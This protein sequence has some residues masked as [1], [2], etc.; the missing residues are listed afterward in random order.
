LAAGR[1]G[2]N[3][4][5]ELL[6]WNYQLSSCWSLGWGSREDAGSLHRVLQARVSRIKVKPSL[7]AQPAIF[8]NIKVGKT[9][10]STSAM[11]AGVG[12]IKINRRKIVVI[13]KARLL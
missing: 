11:N 7:R 4:P 8:I 6:L 9:A 3:E 2:L 13:G 10:M 12:G 1:P 5:P